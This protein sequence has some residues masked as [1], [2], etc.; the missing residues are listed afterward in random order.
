[1]LTQRYYANSIAARVRALRASFLHL[2][3]H[4]LL[5]EDDV[6]F[7]NLDS[8]VVFLIV[9]LDL[10]DVRISVRSFIFSLDASNAVFTV[11]LLYCIKLLLRLDAQVCGALRM[12]PGSIRAF[13]VTIASNE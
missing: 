5:V 11:P 4:D 2:E 6:S 8:D 10:I 3:V 13:F 7:C 9:N 1:L 12:K